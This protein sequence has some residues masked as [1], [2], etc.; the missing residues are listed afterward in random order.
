MPAQRGHSYS[1]P[2]GSGR[3]AAI[4]G[5][6]ALLSVLPRGTLYRTADQPFVA[7]LAAR[8][9]RVEVQAGVTVDGESGHSAW[10]EAFELE[11]S[12][13]P[14]FVLGLRAITVLPHRRHG[15]RPFSSPVEGM[16]E[17]YLLPGPLPYIVEAEAASTGSLDVQ[18]SSARNQSLSFTSLPGA[19]THPLT[20]WVDCGVE[21]GER[22]QVAIT[23]V[24]APTRYAGRVVADS[25]VQRLRWAT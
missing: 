14:A 9:W 3:A 24:A 19:V 16:A 18:T 5:S 12:E 13:P 6:V 17:A 8:R 21:E 2:A 25:A 4:V 1:P 20:T 15:C 7:S 23:G 22:A 11:V 10:S